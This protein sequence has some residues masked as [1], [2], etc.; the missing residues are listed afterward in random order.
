MARTDW[1]STAWAKETPLSTY[2]LISAQLT[3]ATATTIG[4]IQETFLLHHGP[5]YLSCGDAIP[6]TQKALDL[7]FDYSTLV[8]SI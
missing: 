4:H 3:G 2:P 5:L 7:A 8:L 1:R 6:F